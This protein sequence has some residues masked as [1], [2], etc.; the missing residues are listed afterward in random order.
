[1]SSFQLNSFQIKNSETGEIQVISKLEN[2]EEEENERERKKERK[3]A[4]SMVVYKW[5]SV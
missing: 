5:N 3:R 4:Y 1:M 2:G